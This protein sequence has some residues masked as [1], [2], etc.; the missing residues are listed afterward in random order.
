MLEPNAGVLTTIW[1]AEDLMLNRRSY[2]FWDYLLRWLCEIDGKHMVPARDRV[3]LPLED[4]QSS[5]ILCLNAFTQKPTLKKKEKLLICWK[6]ND[7]CHST[8]ADWSRN[9]RHFYWLFNFR[10]SQKTFPT[11]KVSWP[12]A[13]PYESPGGVRSVVW[14]EG[15]KNKQKKNTCHFV[16]IKRCHTFGGPWHLL[17]CVLRRSQDVGQNLSSAVKIRRGAATSYL[18]DN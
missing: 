18:L 4:L 10:S 5:T 8:T 15:K 3:G 1:R 11:A 13:N 7:Q 17:H 9:N 16:Y 6:R 14:K 12:S 2:L